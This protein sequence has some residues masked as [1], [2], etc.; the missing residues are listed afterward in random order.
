MSEPVDPR[1]TRVES[2][3]GVE[4]VYH[5]AGPIFNTRQDVENAIVRLV[6]RE[7]DERE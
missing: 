7:D 6:R 5:V 2:D 3:D 4:I 1:D